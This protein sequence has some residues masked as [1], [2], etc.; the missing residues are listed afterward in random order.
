MVDAGRGLVGGEAKNLRWI[1]GRA[2][3]APLNPPYDLAA[4]GQSLHWMD[5]GV[6]LP[7][8]AS[9]LAPAGTLAIVGWDHAPPAWQEPL[10]ALIRH[11][12]TNREYR[13]YDL[14][15]ELTGRNL[16]VPMGQWEGHTQSY[17]QL[18]ADYVESLHARNGLSWDRMA[19]EAAEEFDQAVHRITQ[20]FQVQGRLELFTA[21]QVV[22]GR[23]RAP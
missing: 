12:S 11:A 19:P 1:V 18:A 3:D 15:Q 4:A 7:R 21:A 8:L 6:V 13:P 20:P 5:W 16:F 2:E 10:A 17:W 23:P 14:V 9:V 22:W